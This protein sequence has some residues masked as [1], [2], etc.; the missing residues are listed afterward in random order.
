MCVALNKI[1]TG[2][3]YWVSFKLLYTNTNANQ[4]S[5]ALCAILILDPLWRQI[6][7]FHTDTIPIEKMV[8]SLSS[9]HVRNGENHRNFPILFHGNSTENQAICFSL[10][11]WPARP[12]PIPSKRARSLRSAFCRKLLSCASW[13]SFRPQRF[14]GTYYLTR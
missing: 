1:D 7:A 2:S 10:A 5:I 13:S 12:T 14:I 4:D 9:H 11:F 8:R 6:P 3:W